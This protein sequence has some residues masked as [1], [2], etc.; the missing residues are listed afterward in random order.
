[1]E[2][3]KDLCPLFYGGRCPI[4]DDEWE[5][6]GMTYREGQQINRDCCA[7]HREPTQ[8]ELEEMFGKNKRN[9]YNDGNSEQ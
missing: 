7:A 3:E 9:E 1:M 5:D 2:K 4:C 8:E 6:L